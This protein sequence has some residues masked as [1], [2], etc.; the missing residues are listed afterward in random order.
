MLFAADTLLWAVMTGVDMAEPALGRV[1]VLAVSRGLDMP[2]PGVCPSGAAFRGAEAGFD[3]WPSFAHR[4]GA[5]VEGDSVPTLDLR[6]PDRGVMFPFNAVGLSALPGDLA[7]TK[8]SLRVE[9]AGDE[10]VEPPP[11]RRGVSG[12]LT[13]RKLELSAGVSGLE[14]FGFVCLSGGGMVEERR[15]RRGERR[16]C[17]CSS[18]RLLS[19]SIPPSVSHDSDG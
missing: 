7:L 3:G 18:L 6:A 19:I 8:G 2:K 17:C 10:A 5:G 4:T 14:V 11:P 15:G 16:S 13:L 12:L 9:S 1:L